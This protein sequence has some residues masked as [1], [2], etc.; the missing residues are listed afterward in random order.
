MDNHRPP[1][2]KQEEYSLSLA[3]AE[4]QHIGRDGLE[5]V[6]FPILGKEFSGQ[7]GEGSGRA[8]QSWLSLRASVQRG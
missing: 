6:I 4:Q 1:L 5:M 7:D 3:L 8:V 2:R